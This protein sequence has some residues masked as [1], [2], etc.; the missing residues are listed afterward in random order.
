MTKNK[1]SFRVQDLQPD[2]LYDTQVRCKYSRNCGYWSEWSHIAINRTPEAREYDWIV[3]R[4]QVNLCCVKVLMERKDVLLCLLKE[5]LMHTLAA[6]FQF[7]K[8]VAVKD[9][10]T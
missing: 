1:E 7:D 8:P 5:V 10:V 9:T 4:I 3:R 6:R 2:T